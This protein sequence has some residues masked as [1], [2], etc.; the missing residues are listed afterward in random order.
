VKMTANPAPT[1]RNEAIAMDQDDEEAE[2]TEKKKL[3]STIDPDEAD[4]GPGAYAV[5]GPGATTSEADQGPIEN[6]VADEKE[7][8]ERN[9]SITSTLRSD[10]SSQLAIDATLVEERVSDELV[11][12]SC[13]QDLEK[14][15]PVQVLAP[16]EV[17]R[18][19]KQDS[20]LVLFACWLVAAC[21]VVILPLLLMSN[22]SDSKP[23]LKTTASPKTT[24][25]P[26]H[27]PPF[28]E[29]LEAGTIK[30]ILED[31]SSPQYHANLWLRQ[32]PAFDSYPEWRKIQRFSLA[33]KYYATNGDQWFRNDHWLSYDVSECHWYFTH[34]TLPTCDDDG[35]VRN[36]YL[37][38]NN[39]YGEVPREVQM[40]PTLQRV[41]ESNNRLYGQYPPLYSHPSIEEFSISNN[42]FE[43]PLVGDAGFAIHNLR[44]LRL[45]GNRFEGFFP[46]MLPLLSTVEVLNITSNLFQG[47]IPTQLSHLTR[48]RSLGLGDNLYSGALPSEIGY[49]S[50]LQELD[51]SGNA[52]LS[53]ALPVELNQLEQ[54]IHLDVAGTRLSGVLPLGLCEE[55]T[56][57]VVANC[58]RIECC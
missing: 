24:P 25:T 39:Q 44:V 38:N 4:S 37:N 41:D 23:V 52:K 51:V 13:N 40:I 29:D 28:L 55:D 22:D 35:Y 5:P 17:N 18:P 47:P 43:G 7:A 57:I 19:H 12:G 56:S 6:V 1:C 3:T 53:G 49:L 45:D 50:S 14:A 46:L 2:Q 20:R 27:Y 58:S 26:T 42:N 21:L 9:E 16:K 8:V 54:L 15:V 48:L 34:P 32:D 36:V 10:D 11:S 31:P 30:A 33:V